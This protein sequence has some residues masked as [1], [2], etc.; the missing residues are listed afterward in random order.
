MTTYVH[1]AEINFEETK[2]RA[3]ARRNALVAAGCSTYVMGLR[4]G[5]PAIQ[6]LCCGLG[7]SS[8]QDIKNR[9]CGFCHAVHEE[10]TAKN[11]K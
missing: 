2:R 9:Y 5:Q 7:S 4:G 11:E 8:F 10:W 6:C 3:A 1:P